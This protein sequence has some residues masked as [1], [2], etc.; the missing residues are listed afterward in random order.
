MDTDDI[1]SDAEIERVHANANF[2]RMSKR[3]VVDE[4]VLKYFFGFTGGSTQIAILIEH[5][6][7]YAPKPGRMTSNLTQKGHDYL[8]TLG[9]SVL[10]AFGKYA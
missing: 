2:G 9:H 6:L 4:G 7:I 3:H 5:G 8:K 1:V 10:E